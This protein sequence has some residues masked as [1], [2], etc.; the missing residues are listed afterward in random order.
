MSHKDTAVS[1]KKDISNTDAYEWELD[2]MFGLWNSTI[3][4]ISDRIQ[5]ARN[6]R[7]TIILNK[8]YKAFFQCD[9]FLHWVYRPKLSAMFM[10]ALETEFE[11]A[12]YLHDEG[13]GIDDNYDLPQ[14]LKKLAASLQ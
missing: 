6:Y 3:W 7:S 1:K 10:L 4:D 9:D 12:L 2:R 5:V 13:Y 11:R 8:V 14:P